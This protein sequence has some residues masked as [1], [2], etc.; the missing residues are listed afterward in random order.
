MER[1]NTTSLNGKGSVVLTPKVVEDPQTVQ[2]VFA[3]EE[4]DSTAATQAKI[5]DAR[6]DTPVVDAPASTPVDAPTEIPADAAEAEKTESPKSP[7]KRPMKLILVAAG[8]GAIAAGA[9]G[10]HWWQYASTHQETDDATVTGH[11]H[12]ISAR[13]PGTVQQVL[14]NDNQMVKAGQPLVKLDPAII[15]F[16]SS[17]RRQIWLRLSKSQYRSNQHCAVCQERSVFH[18]PV[19]RRY[20]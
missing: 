18:N 11:I 2:T 4:F 5:V 6:V 1:L 20:R 14:V 16:D 3:S 8:V 15:K 10:F 12:Q 7:R 17:K 19:S 13:V 9:F